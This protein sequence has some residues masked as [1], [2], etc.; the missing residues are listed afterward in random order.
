MTRIWGSSRILVAA[1]VCLALWVS[2]ATAQLGVITVKSVD[3]ARKA[4]RLLAEQA[5]E[6]DKAD[7]LDQIIDAVTAGKGFAGIDTKKPLG[8]YVGMPAEAGEKPPAVVFIPI[9]KKDD[10]IDLLKG[11][12]VEVGEPENEIHKL[13]PPNGTVTYVRFANGHAY[14]SDN[15]D[16]LKDKLPDPAKFLPA[17]SKTH[18]IA[19]SLRLAQL[20]KKIKQELLDGIA[21]GIEA[22][23]S[24]Q[25]EDEKPGEREG[26]IMGAKLAGEG[27]MAMIR[28]GEDFSL[29]LDINAKS[30][31]ISL[32][33]SLSAAPNSGL[34]ESVKAFG[35]SRSRFSN[36]A[37]DSVFN[38]LYSIPLN[39]DFRK[40][41]YALMEKDMKEGLEKRDPKERKIL[42]KLLPTLRE[43]M[44]VEAMDT[45][46]IIAGPHAD[47]KVTVLVAAHLKNGK[48]FEEEIRALLKEN[49]PEKGKGDLKL[50][51]SKVGSTA[52]HH[53]KP[54]KEADEQAQKALG[55]N[56]IYV[57]VR[58][59]A[60]L[61]TVGSHG[62]EVM[63]DALAQLDKG[64]KSAGTD[65]VQ[66][67]LSIA[68]LAGLAE[69]FNEKQAEA[70]RKVFAGADKGKDRVRLSLLGG[71]SIRL[72]LE[73]NLQV[74][75][76]IAALG[77]LESEQ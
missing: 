48:K 6:K 14:A 17:D 3:D 4:I 71:K 58:E 10:F 16:H 41:F 43:V 37:A 46:I 73:A 55:S 75:K 51:H 68:R 64:A 36:L 30:E 74:I 50:D 34:E 39:K 77:K 61:V 70:I 42:E 54:E 18:L 8:I 56:D 52:I 45:G 25:R 5:G 65:P 63:K 57:A 47:K 23:A 72:R 31:K 60:V 67:E 44:A 53:F 27:F 35:A 19:A 40:T 20:P 76:L 59:D 9:S 15:A 66:V 2:N 49:P 32:D 7:Q 21:K 11:L 22:E 33:L 26:R 28:D 1:C 29:A 62:L 69:N 24:K 13:T 12:Q 38:V